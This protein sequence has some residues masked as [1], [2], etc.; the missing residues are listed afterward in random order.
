MENRIETLAPEVRKKLDEIEEAL[1]E[2]AK[3]SL[4]EEVTP[5]LLAEMVQRYTDILENDPN[6]LDYQVDEDAATIHV[7]LDN[8]TSFITLNLTITEEG[9]EF[10]DAE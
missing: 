8:Q 3:H 6:V 7:Q 2:A 5:K 1:C 10:P 4:F 9:V